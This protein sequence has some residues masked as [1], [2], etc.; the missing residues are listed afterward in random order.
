VDRIS[1]GLFHHKIVLPVATQSLKAVPFKAALNQSLLY[2]WICGTTENSSRTRGD[3]S[4]NGA[5]GTSV[6]LA[7]GA[8]IDE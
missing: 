3:V 7:S 8:H 6:A 5:E 2:E 4:E 1:A